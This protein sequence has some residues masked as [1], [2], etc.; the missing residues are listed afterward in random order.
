MKGINFLA[1]MVLG[2]LLT[3]LSA[4]EN[5]LN[6]ENENFTKLESPSKFFYYLGLRSGYSHQRMSESTIFSVVD[7]KSASLDASSA[8][9]FFLGAHLG[10]G[11]IFSQMFGLRVEAEYGYRTRANSQEKILKNGQFYR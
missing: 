7:D 8:S 1:P 10:F 9:A 6:H 3:L 2:L 5:D 4:E 11:Y